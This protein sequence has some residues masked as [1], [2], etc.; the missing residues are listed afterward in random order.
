MTL[1]SVH[2]NVRAAL[3]RT[4][5]PYL[6]HE[7][8]RLA[9]TITSPV[10]MAR[11]LAIEPARIAK[12]LLLVEQGGARRYALLCC[13]WDAR[14]DLK[15]VASRFGYGRLEVASAQA[16]ADLLGYPR[17]GVSP[18]GAPPEIPLAI[19]VALYHF[20]SVLIGAGM[21]GVEIEMAASDL[22]EMTGAAVGRFTA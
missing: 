11:A 16:L 1:A 15:A 10:D 18:L 7:H 8:H 4:A 13:A 14:A 17:G 5:R 3:E 22:E 6:I 20:P 12:T 2:D 21:S 19:D 9:V